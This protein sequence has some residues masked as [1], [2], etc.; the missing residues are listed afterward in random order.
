MTTAARGTMSAAVLTG[1]RHVESRG[2]PVPDVEPRTLLVRVLTTGVCGSDVAA[3]R[4]THPYKTAPIVL[5][6]ELCGVV[7]RLG[8]GVRG[9]SVGDLVCAAAYSPCERCAACR[10]GAANLCTDRRNLSHLGWQGSFA[11]YVLLHENMAFR[12]ADH[13]D[14][15][16][17]A[18]VEP[19]SIGLHA[20]RL[21]RPAG[22]V[23]VLG[24]GSIGLSCALA[25]KRRWSAWVT[26]VDLGPHKEAPAR[27]AG[28]D[29]Y[30]DAAGDD[31]ASWV[32]LGPADV[33]FVASGHD[34]ALAQ[35]AAM[36]RRGG[37]VVVV[38]YFDAPVLLDANAL[39]GGELALVGSALS[40]AADFAEVID[41]VETGAVDPRPLVTHHFDLAD[42]AGALALLDGAGGRTGKVMIHVSTREGGGR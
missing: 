15:L 30:V 27:L 28:A 33:V 29:D 21:A 25:V 37:Q 13:V 10:A 1:P 26:C 9:F 14:P 12:L 2:I 18:M 34:G 23:V 38:S 3:Y 6:H 7:E 8:D 16:A 41:W 36:V 35:A 42:T 40:T 19:L 4:G 5:G 17:G 39:V 31:F 32:A 20:V 24:S 11:D 22:S